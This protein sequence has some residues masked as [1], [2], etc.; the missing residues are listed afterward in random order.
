MVFK[1]AGNRLDRLYRGCGARLVVPLHDA[2]VFEA[3]LERLGAV[4]ELTERVMIDAVW[5]RFPHLRPRVRL[6]LTD[7]T[8]WNKDG[9]SDSVDRWIEDPLFT[10]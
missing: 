3:P 6:N 4:A 5:A 10:L 1:E 9:H 8:C 7:P 2:F